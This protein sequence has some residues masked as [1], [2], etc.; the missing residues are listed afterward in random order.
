MKA[1]TKE[2]LDFV[3][4][5]YRFQ[6]TEALS[7]HICRELSSVVSC[8][9]VA[10]GRHDGKRRQLS[11][12]IAQ[13]M[14][15]N[16]A[17]LPQF[18][19]E[20]ITATH[21]FWDTVFDPHRPVQHVKDVLPRRQWLQ[22]PFYVEVFAPD[23]LDGHIKMELSGHSDDFITLNILRTGPAFSQADA[24]LLTLLHPHLK[25]AYQ[26]AYML[27]DTGLFSTSEQ[28]L[29]SVPRLSHRETEIIDW[30]AAGKSNE[31]IATLLQISTNTVK[32]HLKRMF[33]KLGVENRTAAVTACKSH[34][35]SQ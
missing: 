19:A 31:E 24:N 22:N 18:N 3:H 27:E 15:S 10:I 8:D 13:H 32:T 23:H 5:L 28:P 7:L 11:A 29:E 26:N 9:N 4:G 25:Q 21:P 30:V 6:T 17:L 2:I 1:N 14:L 34:T 16:A 35:T 12:M 20:G 33:V